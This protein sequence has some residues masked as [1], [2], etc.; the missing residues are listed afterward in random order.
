MQM[1][2]KVSQLLFGAEGRPKY[3][4]HSDTKFLLFLPPRF[5]HSP[6]SALRN[7]TTAHGGQSD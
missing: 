6:A 1:P 2:L 3:F 4:P 7:A 5:F